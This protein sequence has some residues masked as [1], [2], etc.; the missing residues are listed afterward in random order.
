MNDLDLFSRSQWPFGDAG[1]RHGSGLVIIRAVDRES[2]D[3][4]VRDDLGYRRHVATQSQ[5]VRSLT[6]HST[7][8]IFSYFYIFCPLFLSKCLLVQHGD[9]RLGS[10]KGN[11]CTDFQQMLLEEKIGKLKCNEKIEI[12]QALH[13]S[14]R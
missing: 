3:N 13:I 4:S 8:M 2:C 7:R 11:L 14:V 5:A 6:C 12:Q 1:P 9:V 10:E